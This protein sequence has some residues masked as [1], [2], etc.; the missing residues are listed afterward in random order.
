MRS[1]NHHQAADLTKP[2]QYHVSNIGS[3]ISFILV[4]LILIF[5]PIPQ[6]GK[7]AGGLS[8]LSVFAAL[9]FFFAACSWAIAPDHFNN[10]KPISLRHDSGLWLIV[11]LVFCVGVLTHIL[12]IAKLIGLK[13][14]FSNDVWLH[15]SDAARSSDSMLP[16]LRVWSFFTCMW[17]IAWRVS[18]LSERQ[19]SWLLLIVF[20][21][22][23]FQAI[24][25]LAHFI[26]GGSSIL[27]LWDKQYYLG[28]ATG[29]FVNRNHFSGML[30]ISWPLMLSALLANKPL[31]FARHAPIVRWSIAIFYSFIVM[32]AVVSSH[33]RMGTAVALLSIMVWGV[34]YARSRRSQQGQSLRWLPWL[35]IASSI[36]LAVWFGLDDV[37]KRYTVLENGDTRIQIWSALF[38]LPAQAWI[39][40]IGPGNFEDVFRL[41]QPAYMKTRTIH[42]HN[43]YLEFLLEFGLLIGIV[44][45]LS[46]AYW[47]WRLFPRGSMTIRA[48]A[49]GSIA[50][51][52]VHS[53]V[54]FNLQVPGSAVFFWVAVGLMMNRVLLPNLNR[55]D[56]ETLPKSLSKSTGT[57]KIR[58]RNSKR[59]R[60]KVP[61]S[62]QQWFD[63]FR[64]D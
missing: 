56:N 17:I 37:L 53:T 59:R 11:W 57:N 3:E 61:S 48:G 19:V 25:G 10:K 63:L 22:S 15:L 43:D 34:V 58:R 46:F 2:A 27:G 52:A 21:A 8:I 47:F 45:I 51:I 39:V 13:D 40:G 12:L 18:W 49:I 29:T 54:D 14:M 64:S 23:S 16:S 31:L 9:V 4:L 33:S 36:L 35:I 7:M 1:N 20:C 26:T 60:T 42:A 30:A 5:L 28:D 6:S 55:L 41:V 32:L 50:A 38:D 62:K 24:F 44:I